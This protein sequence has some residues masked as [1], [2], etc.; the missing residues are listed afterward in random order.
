LWGKREAGEL[1]NAEPETPRRRRVLLG[2]KDTVDSVL[3]GQDKVR[4]TPLRRII[5]T[6]RAHLHSLASAEKKAIAVS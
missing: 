2:Q 5:H 4:D 3:Q 6:A 1:P